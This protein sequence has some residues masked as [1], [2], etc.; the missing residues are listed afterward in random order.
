MIQYLKNRK[1]AA[2]LTGERE[3]EQGKERPVA[4]FDS[5][6]GGISVLRE[7]VKL[8]PHENFIYYGDSLHAPY[9]TKTLEEVRRLTTDHAEELFE[10]GAKGLVVACNTATSA[11]V[12]SLREQYP[13]VP[14]VGI[15][16][17][18]KPAALCKPHPTVLVMAT[19]MT[20]R[21][22]KFRR[23]MARY[24]KQAEILP[25][26]CP[27]LMDFIERGDLRGEDL[28]RYLEE[29]LYDYR[30]SRVDA[31]VL[32][33]THYPFARELIQQTLGENV[34]IFDGGEGT[35]REMKRRLAVSGLLSSRGGKGSVTFE[36][37]LPDAGKLELCR[38]LFDLR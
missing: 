15:E 16:P 23:L 34:R 21:E 6:V 2:G 36:N 32:G 14:I 33:C 4:V 19:P 38:K 3:T 37:S 13:K 9:G 12:R 8:L 18:V 20:I 22:E 26:P 10:K 25:L 27:G 28:R 35:A 17:A 24:E 11:A 30:G 1:G 31:A 29:L 7:L 5:G